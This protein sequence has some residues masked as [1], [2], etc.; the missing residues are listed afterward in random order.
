[1]RCAESSIKSQLSA[2]MWGTRDHGKKTSKRSRGNRGTNT[3][4]EIAPVPN[5]KNGNPHHS[6]H[7]EYVDTALRRDFFHKWGKINF[8]LK[9]PPT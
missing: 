5:S 9:A 3:G 4:P 2:F 8:K 6:L 1:M 7:V